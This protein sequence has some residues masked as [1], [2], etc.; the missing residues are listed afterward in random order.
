M[1]N[2]AMDVVGCGSLSGESSRGCGLPHWKLCLQMSAGWCGGSYADWPMSEDYRFRSKVWG[3]RRLKR[4]RILFEM[5]DLTG[6]QWR[7]MRVG[8]MWCQGL[9]LMT[10]LKWQPSILSF[11]FPSSFLCFLPGRLGPFHYEIKGANTYLSLDI[12]PSVS[13]SRNLS[14]CL[15]GQMK[16]CENRGVFI[17]FFH[18]LFIHYLEAEKDDGCPMANFIVSFIFPLID[19]CLPEGDDSWHGVHLY[20]AWKHFIVMCTRFL[21]C[22]WSFPG[23][24][25][26][27][28]GTKENQTEI[29]E[30]SDWIDWKHKTLIKYFDSINVI[31]QWT[32]IDAWKIDRTMC[33]WTMFQ[34]L[35]ASIWLLAK[36]LNMPGK[37]KNMCNNWV[38]LFCVGTKYILTPWHT[39]LQQ[40]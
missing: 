36:I 19:H 22:S 4:W 40:E 17:S 26:G 23:S 21:G 16:N 27:Q 29:N 9:V 24:I 8:V 6:S 30:N 3:W 11:F 39:S 38:N 7:W 5:Q 33:Y 35:Y 15:A 20:P 34:H 10:V 25:R 14:H 1:E 32:K 18:Y 28:R 37:K 13:Q 31:V 2:N 12:C